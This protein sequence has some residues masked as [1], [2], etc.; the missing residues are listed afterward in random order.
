MQGFYDFLS[1]KTFI[2][3]D[4]LV[5]L[6]YLGALGVPL[7]GWFMARWLKNKFCTSEDEAKTKGA[8]PTKLILI[9]LA[10]FVLMEVFWRVMFEFLIAYFQMR[11]VMVGL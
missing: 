3:L 11:D 10:M 7:G 2:S 9:F 6:Y 5:V 8:F 1:F 4:V